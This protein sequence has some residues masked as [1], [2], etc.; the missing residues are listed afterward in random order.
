MN[1]PLK[2]VH[3]IGIGGIGMSAIAEMLPC[4]G[5][6]VQGSNNV[7]NANTLRL[8]KKGISVFIGHDEKHLKGVEAV[9]VSSAIHP[10][11]VELMAARKMGIPVA[12]R[13][14]MLAELIRFKKSIS[15]SGS[16]G[17]T[18]TSSLIAH[19]LVTAQMDPSF[20]IGGILNAKGSIAGAGSGDWIVAEADESDGSFLR[21]PSTISV[22]TNIDPEHMDFYKTFHN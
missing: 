10:D 21:L 22:V 15:I 1:F 11:N 18:T 6:T 17:K 2:K 5:V 4:F 16:H 8:Q 12:H 9:V 20:V 19:L 7:E 14:E 13:S 3:F